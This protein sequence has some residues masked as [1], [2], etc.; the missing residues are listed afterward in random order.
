MAHD[1]VTVQ[2][3]TKTL[4]GAEQSP[5]FTGITK[6]GFLILDS[7]LNSKSKIAQ[8]REY[9][10]K[11]GDFNTLATNISGGFAIGGV[12]GKIRLYKKDAKDASTILPGLSDP[13]IHL[14]VTRDSQWILATTKHYL[15]FVP[16]VQ[17]NGKNGFESRM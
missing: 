3:Q 1:L 2:N 4:T 14:E 12:D 10:S 13:I 7:R 6:N 5:L 16:T 17:S 15:L 9:K 8:L 11:V